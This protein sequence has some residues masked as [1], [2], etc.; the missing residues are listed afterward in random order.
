MKLHNNVESLGIDSS[1][2]SMFFDNRILREWIST[3]AAADYLKIT[4]NALRIQV[5]RNKVKA[6][7]FGNRLRFR[8]RDL[9]SLI[10]EKEI[11]DG[12]SNT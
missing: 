6:F 12:D 10:T 2:Q 1:D 5:C 8:I 4:P 7:K 9:K 11:L 3:S